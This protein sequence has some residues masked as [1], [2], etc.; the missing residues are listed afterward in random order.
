MNIKNPIVNLIKSI[1]FPK[2]IMVIAILISILSSIFQLAIPMFTQNLVDNFHQLITNKQYIFI[3]VIVFLL[4]SVLNGL[5][6]F[7]LTKIGESIIYSLIQK[8]WAHILKLSP[9][10]F[11]KNEKGA[12]LSRIVDDTTVINNFITQIIPTFFPAIITLLG[13]VILLFVLDWQTAIIAL[14]SIPIYTILIIP[15]SKIMQNLA[16]NTQ[17]E[18]AKLSSTIFD[19]L[20]KINL[21]KVSNTELKEFNSTKS[22]LKKIYNLGV[23]EG[24]INSI[25]A[26]ITSL[27]MLVSMGSVLAFGGFRVSSGAISAGTLI[28]LI[29]YLMQLTEPVQNMAGIFTGYKKMQ[30]SSLRL[31]EIMQEPEENLEYSSS[32]INSSSIIFEN[33]NF[34]YNKG[35][36]VLKNCS[37]TIPEKKMT[38]LVG[39][40][41]SG[42]TTIFNI[43]S[44]LYKI[45][46][47]RV[48]YGTKSIYDF[49]LTDWRNNVGYVMQDNG[50]MSGTIKKNIS[51]ALK[52]KPNEED[53]MYYSDLAN[54][55]SF[56]NKFSNGYNTIIG[57]R[58]I[59]LSGGEKQRIDIARNFI[60]N[61]NL[62]LLDEATSNLDSESELSIQD[63][64]NNISQNRTT[65]IIAHRLSTILKA[66]KILF[67]EDGQI[68]GIGTHEDL[69]KTHK[70]Y[71]NMVEIQ[72]LNE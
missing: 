35:D 70:R 26:P 2:F 67:V 60:K 37:F 7:L 28:A 62:L 66:D 23:K 51:Y 11:D 24:T 31:V 16:F 1:K 32:L 41:G 18:T 22:K 47:G 50:I 30:G 45:D 57:E 9:S 64:L 12:L 38:A 33:V 72:N 13:S 27:L 3:F 68:T 34:R 10:F 4:N 44:R 71:K 54:A 59:Q 36:R 43:I 53:L 42:K 46:S 15:L 63:A 48:L 52:R 61:P 20:S 6:I 25:V 40:S 56:I 17:L 69:I 49:S 21:V 8:V 14:L 55:N 58:G 5:S 65:V 29:F 19:V 39:P